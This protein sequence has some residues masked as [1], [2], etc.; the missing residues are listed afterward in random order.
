MINHSLTVNL[1]LHFSLKAE[2]IELVTIKANENRQMYDC[3]HVEKW[4]QMS[5]K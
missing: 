5:F 3:P 2:V 4:H 1:K